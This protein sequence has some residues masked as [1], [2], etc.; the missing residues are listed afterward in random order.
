MAELGEAWK[1]HALDVE[2]KAIAE[3]QG[4]RSN[5]VQRAKSF[6]T[7]NNNGSGLLFQSGAEERIRTRL[8]DEGIEVEFDPSPASPFN[9]ERTIGS[10]TIAAHLLRG[11]APDGPVTPVG[12]EGGFAFA[13]G[14]LR[15][16]YDRHGLHREG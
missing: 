4:A 2:G 8:G 16:R 7:D 13:I 11:A 6:Y 14:E 15:F 5:V 9:A 1:V 3:V 12:V 10:V